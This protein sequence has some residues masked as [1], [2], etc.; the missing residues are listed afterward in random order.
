MEI[1]GIGVRLTDQRNRLINLNGLDWDISLQ[2]DF[3]EKPELKVPKDKRLLIHE[4]LYKD[5]Q[6]TKTQKSKD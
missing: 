4:K 1:T 6:E 5:Y 2:F 3:V